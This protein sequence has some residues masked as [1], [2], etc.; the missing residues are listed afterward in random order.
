MQPIGIHRI[1]QPRGPTGWRLGDI[2]PLLNKLSID[3]DSVARAIHLWAMDSSLKEFCGEPELLVS[4]PPKQ[5]G[6]R[7]RRCAGPNLAR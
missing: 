5:E 4:R 6:P 7:D 1:K 2:T 3:S